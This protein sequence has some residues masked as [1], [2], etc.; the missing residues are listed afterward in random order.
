MGVR[1]EVCG[2]YGVFKLF[3]LG[4]VEFAIYDW[5]SGDDWSNPNLNPNPKRFP[6]GSASSL[7]RG[8]FNAVLSIGRLEG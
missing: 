8:G 3:C 2:S 6:S 5:Q 4:F 1:V 7:G